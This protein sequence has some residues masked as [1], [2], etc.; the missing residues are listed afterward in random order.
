[1]IKELP[2]KN[3]WLLAKTFT[4]LENKSLVWSFY[5]SDIICINKSYVCTKYLRFFLC[6]TWSWFLPVSV[7]IGKPEPEHVWSAAFDG[8]AFESVSNRSEFRWLSPGQN[9]KLFC[10]NSFQFLFA[11]FLLLKVKVRIFLRF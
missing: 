6:M 9:F 11:S 3:F 5:L 4:R 10:L 1:M 2:L 8:R 7:S